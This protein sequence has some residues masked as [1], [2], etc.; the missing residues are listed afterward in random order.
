MEILAGD[1][2]VLLPGTE[3]WL[4]IQGTATFHV[5]AQSSFKL[6][7]HSVTDYCCSYP[8]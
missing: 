4:E 7:V 6:E 5:P 2:K 8:A 1:L 3:E